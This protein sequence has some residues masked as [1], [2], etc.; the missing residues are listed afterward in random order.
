MRICRFGN[1]RIG[2]VRGDLVHDVSDVLERLGVHRYPLPRYDLL[3]AALDDLLPE[4][5]AAAALVE[6]I[7]FNGLELLA[8]V[9]NPGKIVAAPVNYLKH[10][11]EA[12]TDSAIHHQNQVGEIDRVG[13][14]LKATSSLVGASHGVSLRFPDR[15]N[16]H[17]IELVAV[18]GR[19]AD[20]VSASRALDYVAGYSIGLD[21]TVRGPEERSMRKSIDTYSVLGPMLVTR[22]EFGDPAGVALELTVNGEPRQIANTRDLVLSIPE[23]I[24]R[25]S[26]YYTLQP[27]D[28]I[29]TG[30]PEGVAAVLPGDTITASIERI[31]TIEVAVTGEVAE[32]DA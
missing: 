6:G 19:V 11:E 29:Y 30:T 28:L 2:L 31:G 27:G 20:R 7:P 18:I 5:E 3:L 13:L 21:M 16:D 23:L 14:F 32:S 24:E 22:D 8:P 17:E 25:A 26:R 12:R 1:D 10:L 4:F 9:A 15:R